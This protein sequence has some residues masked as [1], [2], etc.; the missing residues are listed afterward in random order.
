MNRQAALTG[1]AA[2]KEQAGE[3][4]FDYANSHADSQ[5]NSQAQRG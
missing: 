3:E 1:G 2:S 4:R 5:T